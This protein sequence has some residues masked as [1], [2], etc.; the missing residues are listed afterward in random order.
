MLPGIGLCSEPCSRTPLRRSQTTSTPRQRTSPKRYTL[1]SQAPHHAHTKSLRGLVGGTTA[2]EKLP[3]STVR[4]AVQGQPKRRNGHCG[5]LHARQKGHTGAQQSK[6]Q[7]T[8]LACT[9]FRRCLQLGQHPSPF[10]SAQVVI[11]P[12]PGDRNRALPKSYRPIAL[13]SCLGK[14]LER[15]I[16][17]RLVYLALHHNVLARDQCGATSR[18]AATD[19]TTAL[20]SDIED[21]WARRATGCLFGLVPWVPKRPHNLLHHVYRLKILGTR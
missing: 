16:A 5:L 3:K 1:P 19:L 11:I 9:R 18:R 14:G 2:V 10:K 8:S 21:I 12:K 7:T 20:Y 15:L 6:E 17:R 4:P 13:L